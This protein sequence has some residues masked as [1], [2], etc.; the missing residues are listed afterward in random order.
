ME[1]AFGGRKLEKI[2][3]GGKEIDELDEGGGAAGFEAR[4]ADD[5]RNPH[6]FF[7]QVH[8]LP[9]SVFAK[10][11]AVISGEDDPG[12]ITQSQP[13]QLVDDAPELLVHE[14]D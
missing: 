4:R 3:A 5:E 1:Q 10:M 7:V 2:G 6:H 11:I 8:L 9:E 12:G 13:L 14:G